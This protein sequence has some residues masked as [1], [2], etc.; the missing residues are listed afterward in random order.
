[1]NGQTKSYSE[2]MAIMDEFI[3]RVNPYKK[4]EPLNFDIRGYS[5]YLEKHGID[6]KNVPQHIVD[7]FRL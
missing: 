6:G 5:N 2:K 1:M 3:K 4:H 7:M